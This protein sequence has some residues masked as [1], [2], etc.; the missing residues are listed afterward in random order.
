MFSSKICGGTA[1]QGSS[2][3]YV[4]SFVD[5]SEVVGFGVWFV[6]LQHVWWVWRNITLAFVVGSGLLWI[7][8]I[9]FVH[10]YYR[11]SSR[12]FTN[13]FTCSFFS[14]SVDVLRG[15]A[16]AH[17]CGTSTFR[18]RF[19]SRRSVGLEA[20]AAMPIRKRFCARRGCQRL[21][22]ELTPQQQ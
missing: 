9:Q 22:A 19:C 17:F 11:V 16:S 20:S 8:L 18:Q 12:V 1:P 10:V 6:V 21:T 13:F 3:A 7:D 5:P 2:A 15:F 4:P 14:N